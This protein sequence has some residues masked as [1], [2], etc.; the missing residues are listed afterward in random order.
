MKP[1]DAFAY[2]EAESGKH[3]DPVCVTAFVAARPRVF[4]FLAASEG[5]GSGVAAIPL[6]FLAAAG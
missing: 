5:H 6:S 2:V 4:A 3:F 1:D